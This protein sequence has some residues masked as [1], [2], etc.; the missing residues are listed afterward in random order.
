MYFK[1]GRVLVYSVTHVTPHFQNSDKYETFSSCEGNFLPLAE[2][3]YLFFLG[4]YL[5]A[6]VL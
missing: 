3:T 5:D 6:T 1:T 2:L 4:T